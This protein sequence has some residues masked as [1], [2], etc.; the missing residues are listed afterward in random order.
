M[1]RGAGTPSLVFIPPRVSRSLSAAPPLFCRSMLSM[2]PRGRARARL[3]YFFDPAPTISFASSSSGLIG[4]VVFC[5]SLRH[6]ESPV[7]AFT[8]LPLRPLAL[9]SLAVLFLFSLPPS[10]LVGFLLYL[11]CSLFLHWFCPRT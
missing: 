3:L 8:Q 7:S 2:S 1:S 4:F 9:A 10:V 11:V 5:F 6:F